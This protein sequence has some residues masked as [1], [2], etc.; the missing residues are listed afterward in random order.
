[1]RLARTPSGCADAASPS[2]VVEKQL[3][4]VLTLQSQPRRPYQWG[5]VAVR[6][7]NNWLCDVG[8]C[9]G[10]RCSSTR[11]ASAPACGG[12]S[13]RVAHSA[14]LSMRAGRFQPAALGVLFP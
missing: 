13:S 1:M 9:A 8:R 7:P 12:S 6:A 11:V 10:M 3:S 14:P 2:P 5:R 4:L